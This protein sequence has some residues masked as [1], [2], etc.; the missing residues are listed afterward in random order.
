MTVPSPYD[1]NPQ[2]QFD[3]EE[4]YDEL[5]AQ[6][7]ALSKCLDILEA[8]SKKVCDEAK[9]LVIEYRSQNYETSS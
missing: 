1:G 2:P 8:K 4:E 6:L 7:D 9:R 5:N 3:F